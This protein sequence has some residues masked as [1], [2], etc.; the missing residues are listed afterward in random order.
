M[1]KALLPF[2]SDCDDLTDEE[3]DVCVMQILVREIINTQN[4]QIQTMRGVLERANAPPAADCEVE[5]VTKET[6]GGD[7][8]CY[9]RKIFDILA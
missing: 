8:A 1:A 7:I 3:D 5:V 9:F 2:V 4:F 6:C